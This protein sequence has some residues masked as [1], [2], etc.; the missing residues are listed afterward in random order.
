MSNIDT[1]SNTNT[2]TN[3]YTNPNTDTKELTNKTPVY[4]PFQNLQKAVLYK[5]LNYGKPYSNFISYLI[6]ENDEYIAKIYVDAEP[7]TIFNPDGS[8]PEVID[9]SR[10]PHKVEIHYTPE[11]G[12]PITYCV[13]KSVEIDKLVSKYGCKL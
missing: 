5:I 8:V 10:I 2:D 3:I 12:K 7:D 11:S 4:L 9:E 13:L 6:P 1:N